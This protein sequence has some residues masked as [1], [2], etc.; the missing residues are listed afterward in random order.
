MTT[1]AANAGFQ[2]SMDESGNIPALN[3]YWHIQE[4][5]DG[6]FLARLIKSGPYF[7][8]YTLASGDELA[9]DISGK[10]TGV[11]RELTLTARVPLRFWSERNSADDYW[12]RR[13]RRA[14]AQAPY[15]AVCF[16]R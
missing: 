12:R 13:C 15:V 10:V 9:T 1:I 6:F 5:A 16:R 2:L 8:T 3:S 4:A 11:V 14:R 7:T